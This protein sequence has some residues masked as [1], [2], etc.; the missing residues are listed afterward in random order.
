MPP[1]EGHSEP[2]IFGAIETSVNSGSGERERER[3][4]IIVTESLFLRPAGIKWLWFHLQLNYGTDPFFLAELRCISETESSLGY[5]ILGSIRRIDSI[6]EV[7][8][9]NDLAAIKP[10]DVILRGKMQTER[11]K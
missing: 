5:L 3:C 6:V 9:I 4:L 11:G 7:K 2:G 10:L 1:L 8:G